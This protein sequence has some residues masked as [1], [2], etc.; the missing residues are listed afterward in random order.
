MQ[1]QSFQQ[2][3][4][5]LARIF[6]DRISQTPRNRRKICL[7]LGAGADISS[8]GL[9]FQQFKRQTLEEYL[10]RPLFDVTTNEQIQV[11]FDQVMATLS[12]ADR[13]SIVDA[14][15]HR[16]EKLQ[17]S[18]SYRLLVLLAEAG[19]VDAV[20]TTNFDVMLEV[21]QRELGRDIFQVYAPGNARPYKPNGGQT[22]L[23]KIPYLKI[24]GDLGSATVTI[25]TQSEID[26]ATYD[27][28]MLELLTSIVSTHDLVVAGYGGFDTSLAHHMLAALKDGPHHIFWSA[29]T[30]PTSELFK[31]LSAKVK[32][33]ELTFDNLI[34]RIARPVLE[35][36]RVSVGRPSFVPCLYDWRIA[37]NNKNFY[38][39]YA[40]RNGKP[41]HKTFTRRA[42]VEECLRRFIIAQQPLAIV[43]GPSGFGKTTIGIRLNE[44]YRESPDTK[45]LLIPSRQLTDILDLEEY[46]CDLLGGLGSRTQFRLND[47]ER[48][49]R[50]RGSRLLLFIDA[51]NEFSTNLDSCVH[52]TRSVLRLS[53]FMPEA[54]SALRFIVTVRQETWAQMLPRLDET[55]LRQNLWQQHSGEH[56][57]KTISCE[58]FTH[59]EITD[60]LGLLG[61]SELALPDLSRASPE[62]WLQ[63]RDPYLFGVLSEAAQGKWIGIPRALLFQ[64]TFEAKLSRPDIGLSPSILRDV[65]AGVAVKCLE[66]GV[67]RAVDIEPAYAREDIVRAL[68]DLNILIESSD[69]FLEFSHDRTFEYFLALAL[70]SDSARR[71]DST[72]SLLAYLKAFAEQG[73]AL[74]A[75]RLYF[76][77]H[78]TLCFRLVA[79]C[80]RYVDERP[81]GYTQPEC[82]RLFN[83]ARDVIFDLA[84]QG[85]NE[86]CAYLKDAVSFIRLEPLRAQHVRTVIQ[87][88]ALLPASQAIE[89]LIN[90]GQIASPQAADEAR[91][92]AIDRLVAH[93]LNE[94]Q[95]EPCLL[96][97]AP[98]SNFLAQEGPAWQSLGR[99]FGL[100][101][102]LG[103]DNLH[104]REFEVAQHALTAAWRQLVDRTA[105][106]ATDVEEVTSALFSRCD[107]LLFNATIDGIDAFYSRP[108]T[109]FVAILD[110]LASGQV[111][112]DTDY[113][114]LE[115]HVGKLDFDIEYHG[116][117]L[118]IV[119]S[120]LNDLTATIDF[121]ETRLR[122]VDDTDNPVEVDFLQAALVYVRLVNDLRY[123]SV[124]D[125]PIQERLLAHC[126]S[127][128]MHRP[129]L[130]RGARRGFADSFDQIFEDGFG[131][132]YPYGLQEPS[133]LR[134]DHL[135]AEYEWQVAQEHIPALPL[136]ADYL[137]RYLQRGEFDLA[138]QLL[139]TLSGVIV[140][141]PDV[142]LR[143]IQAAIGYPHDLIRRASLRVLAEAYGRHPAKTMRFLTSSG[144]ALSEDDLLDIRGRHEANIGRRQL[145]EI[146]HGR[147]LRFLLSQDGAR[148]QLIQG[149]R[150][151]FTASNARKAIEGLV[152]QFGLSANR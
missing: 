150:T 42:H 109:A 145:S 140:H 152:S 45:V 13:A 108:R 75:A 11:E 84:E 27:E 77:L 133:I 110:R 57:I 96:E 70:G 87:A 61:E 136:Y 28:S 56:G 78:T 98:F 86:I 66:N 97:D 25:V 58:P 94:I 63:L 20:I 130:E 40:V 116:A 99:L 149:L 49:L 16:M 33:I 107:R 119:L 105:F 4:A 29:P 24:H 103:R 132:V 83:F 142:G 60:A 101:S 6:S 72:A 64:R 14:M 115:A 122:R 88:I 124:R 89:M 30:P 55:L 82:E 69:R 85:G 73:K 93:F 111:F 100:V 131:V 138:L 9:T 128:L 129:G 112:G 47:L 41:I 37:Y 52:F 50:E 81:A 123:D 137:N 106:S 76:Q 19:A 7:F 35:K 39:T 2:N 135:A 113:A 91:I 44:I 79:P 5:L 31:Q 121:L 10:G 53:N 36:P 125:W 67:C 62:F 148:E 71:L 151:V 32:F 114:A 95:K 92:F 134:R 48:W 38:A 43:T 8:G 139:Q 127:I 18:D 54:S 146:E 117:H 68:K 26:T 120:S 1:P 141:W 15:F 144:V 17:P 51:I 147:I 23:P 126:P 3:V 90:L 12:Q 59:Q 22:Y 46:V 80:L 21:A 104:D 143:A 34:E 65:L 118:L 102:E 74:A